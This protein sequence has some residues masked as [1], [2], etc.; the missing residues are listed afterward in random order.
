MLAL[1]PALA[2]ALAEGATTL[3]RC[4]LLTRRDGTTLGFTDHDRPLGLDGVVCAPEAAVSASALERAEG[5][6]V[7]SVEIVGALRGDAVR[8]ADIERGLYD[9]AEIALWLV[10][11]RAPENRVLSHRGRLGEI[12]RVSGPV[13]APDAPPDAED[14]RFE[15]EIEGLSES[16]NRPQ[17]RQLLGVCDARLG[18]GRCG[19]DLAARARSGR[20]LAVEAP[21]RIAVAGLDDAPSGAFSRGALTWTSG[22]NAGDALPIKRH[23]KDGARSLLDF[24]SAPSRPIAADD[25]F[26]AE[27]GC[28]KRFETCRDV[29]QNA[30][31]FRGFPHTPGDDWIASYP[32]EG[33][34]H[35][36][37]ARS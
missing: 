7:D 19:V 34:R 5:L 4:W 36:G 17:G 35:D 28:D 23:A 26:S 1:P 32:A 9:G 37:G 2:E 20:V 8:D 15:A 10:D 30:L 18:D 3:C 11:W 14:G 21:H 25:A 31:N 27:P 16:L 29:F 33:G 22:P 13:A 6:A 12:R 24:W